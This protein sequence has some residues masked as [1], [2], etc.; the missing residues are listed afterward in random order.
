MINPSRF[1]A[2]S[3]IGK[4]VAFSAQPTS[5]G[6]YINMLANHLIPLFAALSAITLMLAPYAFD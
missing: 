1:L 6:L 2:F 3:F 5:T 4:V